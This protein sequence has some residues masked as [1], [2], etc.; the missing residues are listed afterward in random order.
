MCDDGYGPPTPEDDA[1]YQHH[2]VSK[3]YPRLKREPRQYPGQERLMLTNPTLEDTWAW[4]VVRITDTG[5]E[6][7]HP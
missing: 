7:I 3:G 5:I 6:E 2:V 1:W 4:P